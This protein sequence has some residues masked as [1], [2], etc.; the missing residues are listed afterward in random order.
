MAVTYTT[1]SGVTTARIRVDL[2]P[3]EAQAFAE[4]FR[5]MGEGDE[6]WPIFT[7]LR[8]IAKAVA[9]EGVGEE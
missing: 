9:A 1:A 2:T 6:T 4:S 8:R 5:S 7:G 3:A